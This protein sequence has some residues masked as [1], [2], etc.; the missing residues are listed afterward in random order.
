M[1]QANILI[2]KDGIPHIAGLGNV[3]ILPQSTAWTVEGRTSADRLSRRRAPELTCPGMLPNANDPTHPTGAS[4]MYSFGVMTWEVCVGRL[5]VIF[6]VVRFAHS[7]QVLTGRLP[8]PEMTE[9]AATYSM[10]SGARPPRPGHREISDR[11]WY[12]IE[13]CWHN[14]PSKRMPAGEVVDLVETELRCTS[15]SQT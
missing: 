10:M 2:D 14:V 12:M 9:I 3:A 15:D 13:R 1:S 11:V 8:F 5:C 4:D 6:S 7:R